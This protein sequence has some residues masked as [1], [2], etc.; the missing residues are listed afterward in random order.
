MD[1]IRFLFDRFMIII[2]YIIIKKIN[3][4]LKVLYYL[5]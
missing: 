3:F 1:E 4:K 5:L 2:Y